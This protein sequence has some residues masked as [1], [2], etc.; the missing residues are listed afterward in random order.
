M[1][2][3]NE[4]EMVTGQ[5]FQD[6]ETDTVHIECIQYYPALIKRVKELEEAIK[7]ILWLNECHCDEAYTGRRR[8][9]PNT[10]CGE[11]DELIEILNE[12]ERGDRD[13]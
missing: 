11:L 2:L 12:T 4:I 7:P 1:K 5:M 3:M 13:K 8:H 10:H 9:A 6:S